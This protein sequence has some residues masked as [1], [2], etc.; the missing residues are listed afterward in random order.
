[1][2]SG[3]SAPMIAQW[4]TR[5][6]ITCLW[7]LHRIWD[8]P[9]TT[10]RAI[11]PRGG[12]EYQEYFLT[13]NN[14]QERVDSGLCELWPSGYTPCWS[15]WPVRLIQ[16][17][18]LPIPFLTYEAGTD[19]LAADYPHYPPFQRSQVHRWLK[20]PRGYK[21]KRVNVGNAVNRRRSHGHADRNFLASP[22]SVRV[23]ILKVS[24]VSDFSCP[25]RHP[26]IRM[27]KCFMKLTLLEGSRTIDNGVLGCGQRRW[28]PNLKTSLTNANPVF[29]DFLQP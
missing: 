1:M 18:T 2:Y 23:D 14:I 10:S 21:R 9:T 6:R 17:W 26:K 11:R 8:H 3:I 5:V 25:I 4:T 24:E 13:S 19:W 15:G 27:E 22:E 12:V 16:D 20:T 28:S 29:Q 7:Q